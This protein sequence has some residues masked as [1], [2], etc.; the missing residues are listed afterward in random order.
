M[1]FVAIKAGELS[2][3][4]TGAVASS[5]TQQTPGNPFDKDIISP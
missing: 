5:I 3:S 4:P 2:R 1:G